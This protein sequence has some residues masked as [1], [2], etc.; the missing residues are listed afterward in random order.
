MKY[1]F[2]IL[3]LS[4]LTFTAESKV[5]RVIRFVPD[6]LSLWWEEGGFWTFI[7]FVVGIIIVLCITFALGLV[8]GIIIT[9]QITKLMVFISGKP[10]EYYDEKDW[11]SNTQ[12]VIGLVF[13]FF[14]TKYITIPFLD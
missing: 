11:V 1:F 13:L 8:V 14:V 4:F 7:P 3:C 12:L 6:V 10:Q 2:F 5:H 9:K